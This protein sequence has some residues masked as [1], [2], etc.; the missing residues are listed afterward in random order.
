[1]NRKNA[2]GDGVNNRNDR[3][4]SQA[5]QIAGALRRERARAGQPGYDP[6]RHRRLVAEFSASLAAVPRAA[7]PL[8]LKEFLHIKENKH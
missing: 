1:M 7:R 3:L 5:R 8:R 2:I 4:L 6:Q